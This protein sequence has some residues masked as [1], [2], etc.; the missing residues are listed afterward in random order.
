VGVE[1]KINHV[2]IWTNQLEAMK[3][4]YCQY[5]KGKAGHKYHNKRKEFE[6]YFISFDEGARIELMTMPDIVELEA[7]QL[8]SCLGLAHF[9]LSVGSEMEVIRIT[10][11]LR[12]DG[13]V[14]ASEPRVTGDN[15]YESVVLD[16]DGNCVEI[17][18]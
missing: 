11:K 15:Y 4:F 17:T 9:A 3:T 7:H 14:I 8:L 10:E 16:P 5:F 12:S 6:S 18:V 2:A 13:Y 1:L